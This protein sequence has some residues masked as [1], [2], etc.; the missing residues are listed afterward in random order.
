MVQKFVGSSGSVWFVHDLYVLFHSLLLDVR[1]M[2][3]T[4]I[5]LFKLIKHTVHL[6][7]QLA[8]GTRKCEGVTLVFLKFYVFF[9]LKQFFAIPFTSFI[10][11]K[12]MIF[13]IWIDS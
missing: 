4:W 1:V 10:I 12:Y 5:L 6:E 2:Q 11:A 13:Y 8:H 3:I 9:Y 7:K